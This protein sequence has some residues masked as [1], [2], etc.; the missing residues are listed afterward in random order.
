MRTRMNKLALLLSLLA[1]GALG[2]VACGGGDDDDQ[3]AAASESETTTDE[4]AAD[5]TAD[6]KSCGR[7]GRY[8]FAVVD[9]DVSCRVARRVMRANSIPRTMPGSWSC[10]G[11][12]A[13]WVCVNEAG[14]MIK[15]YVTCDANRL[16]HGDPNRSRCPG[17]I[18]RSEAQRRHGRGATT[19]EDTAGGGG[20]TIEV[21]MTEYAFDPADVTVSKGDTITVTNDGQL[22][23]NYTEVPRGKDYGVK[24]PPHLRDLALGTGDVDP[25]SSGEFEVGDMALGEFEVICTIPGHAEKGMKGTLTVE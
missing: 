16:A 10:G 9:G 24:L 11:S 15:A 5:N 13:E 4:L 8:R 22:P 6:H 18:K 12:D 1:L 25:G 21:S 20:G 2:L 7:V 17:W 19:T 23:H 14:E 3:S